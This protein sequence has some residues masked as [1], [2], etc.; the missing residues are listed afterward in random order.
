MVMIMLGL[1]SWA[2]AAPWKENL[3]GEGGSNHPWPP[4]SQ[5]WMEDARVVNVFKF[6]SPGFQKSVVGH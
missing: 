5:S 2:E 1:G 3:A 6:W 4:K